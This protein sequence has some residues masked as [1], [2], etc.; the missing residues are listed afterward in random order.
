MRVIEYREQLLEA[1][2]ADRHVEKIAAVVI[3]HFSQMAPCR[4][5]KLNEQR[6][7]SRSDWK[8]RIPILSLTA[9][10][11]KGGEGKAAAAGA[12]V[13]MTKPFK[14]DCLIAAVKILAQCGRA[15]RQNTRQAV[16]RGRGRNTASEWRMCCGI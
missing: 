8:S 7:R 10:A 5:K 14:V 12:D 1:R 15:L 6:I 2:Y 11:T 13:Y 9:D 4:L 16:H 3:P